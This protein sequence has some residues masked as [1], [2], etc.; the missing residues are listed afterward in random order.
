V[1]LGSLENLARRGTSRSIPRRG[2]TAVLKSKSTLTTLRV[3]RAWPSARAGLCL[4]S[5]VITSA[6]PRSPRTRTASRPPPRS[7]KPSARRASP[8]AISAR[9]TSSPVR[10]KKPVSESIIS[11][12]AGSIPRWEDSRHR[13]RLSPRQRKG[14]RRGIGTRS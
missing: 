10:G 9:T 14:R 5:S 12:H 3:P 1:N 7:T 11:T 13:I 6:V 4:S 8:P 2:A